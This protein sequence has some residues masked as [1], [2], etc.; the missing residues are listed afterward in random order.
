MNELESWLSAMSGE[1]TYDSSGIFTLKVEAVPQ[2]LASLLSLNPSLPWLHL[3]QWAHRCGASSL[4]FNSAS[5]SLVFQA[6]G[7][8]DC[9]DWVQA[10]KL[11]PGGGLTRDSLS[12]TLSL[13]QAHRPKGLHV[14]CRGTATDFEWSRDGAFRTIALEAGQQPCLEVRAQLVV[15]GLLDML[16]LSWPG[17]T[18]RDKECTKTF[19]RPPP[20]F[21][22]PPS[23][24]TPPRNITWVCGMA[25]AKPSR[26]TSKHRFTGF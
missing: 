20:G 9:S 19:V 10:L 13:L 2:A 7:V 11:F 6:H 24:G 3:V 4:T 17:C 15:P 8:H 14:K 16:R 25:K 21:A 18:T 5:G 1:T 23:R 22:K 26:R 12:G